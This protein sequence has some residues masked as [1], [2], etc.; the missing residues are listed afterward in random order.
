[1]AK[2]ADVQNSS[3]CAIG[4]LSSASTKRISTVVQW[5]QISRL[6]KKEEPGRQRPGSKNGG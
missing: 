2:F 1:M 4:H 6:N 5:E 3:A